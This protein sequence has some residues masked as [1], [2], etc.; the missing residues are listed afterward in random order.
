MLL[1]HKKSVNRVYLIFTP[2]M[3]VRTKNMAKV[4]LRFAL[5]RDE[6]P[7]YA[8]LIAERGGCTATYR[9][10]QRG[11][12]RDA[13]GQSEKLADVEIVVK[14][15]LQEGKRMSCAPDDISPPSS[16]DLKSSRVAGYQLDP[17]LARKLGLLAKK[18][19]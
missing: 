9:I 4:D 13:Y 10:S 5:I 19:V 14:R 3:N 8:V 7:W 6:K 12:S 17:S 11:A 15:V 2:L 16:L 18:T 1:S